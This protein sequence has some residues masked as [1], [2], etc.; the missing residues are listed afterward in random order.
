MRQTKLFTSPKFSCLS[1]MYV[2]FYVMK[3]CGTLES[4]LILCVNLNIYKSY[5]TPIIYYHYPSPIIFP[6]I[7]NL[8]TAEAIKLNIFPPEIPENYLDRDLLERIM[9]HCQ[10]V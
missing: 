4:K 7:P 2:Y 6:S 1:H 5:M 9:H 8:A 10:M 3:V